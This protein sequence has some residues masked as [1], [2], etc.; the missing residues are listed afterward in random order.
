MSCIHVQCL[1]VISF[2][3][4]SFVNSFHSTA[5]FPLGA[6]I[7]IVVGVVVLACVLS[8]LVPVLICCFLGVGVCAA[9]GCAAKKKKDETELKGGS[10]L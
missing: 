6:I 3:V 7:G 5:I 4:N 10:D 9:V 2:I 8:I 1:L